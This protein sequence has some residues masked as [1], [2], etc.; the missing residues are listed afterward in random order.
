[1]NIGDKV[2]W[3]H[4]SQRGRTMSMTLREGVIEQINGAVATVRTPSKRQVIVDIRRLR[5]EGQESQISEFVGAMRESAR[6]A[7]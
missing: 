1:M 3:T 4:V 5:L 2:S 6:R 7:E